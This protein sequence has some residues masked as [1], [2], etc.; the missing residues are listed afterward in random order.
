MT[1]NWVNIDSTSQGNAL[2]MKIFHLDIETR[3]H[4]SDPNP[5]KK[6]PNTG[7]NAKMT[8][9]MVDIKNAS[10]R[11]AQKMKVSRL[12]KETQK[13]FIDTNIAPH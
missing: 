4:F 1:L 11:Y 6:Q 3:K 10:Q 2:K 13:Q 12:Y 9:K 8:I 7:Q 5:P